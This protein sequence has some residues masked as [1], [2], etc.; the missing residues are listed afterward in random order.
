MTAAFVF[1][2]DALHKL[3]NIFPGPATHEASTVIISILAAALTVPNFARNAILMKWTATKDFDF[4]YAAQRT[5]VV[6]WIASFLVFVVA[7]VVT[8]LPIQSSTQTGIAL[9]ATLAIATMAFRL[10]EM[11]RTIFHTRGL[12]LLCLESFSQGATSNPLDANRWHLMTG[13]RIIEQSLRRYGVIFPNERLAF[14]FNMLL[15]RGLSFDKHLG[16]LMRALSDPTATNLKKATDSGR[17]LLGY[18]KEYVEVGVQIP[19]SF[20]KRFTTSP[21]L[22]LSGNV[23]NLLVAIIVAV[24]VLLGIRT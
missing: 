14:A 17:S 1:I 16:N 2:F 5:S 18:A 10:S 8:P 19:Y 21:V 22:E 13:L 7:F 23:V 11:F 24:L 4:M 3:S 6:I 15:L 12:G 20:W 9:E